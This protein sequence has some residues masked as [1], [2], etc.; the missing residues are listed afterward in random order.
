MGSPDS[1][2]P[3][4]AEVEGYEQAEATPGPSVSPSFALG[5]S[6]VLKTRHDTAKNSI[7]NVR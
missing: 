4:D 1:D 5:V 3:T 6:N 7:S 2:E